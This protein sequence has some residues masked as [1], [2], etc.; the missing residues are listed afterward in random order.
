VRLLQIEDEPWDSGLA[1]Y[2]LTLSAELAR[3]GHEVNFWGRPHSPLLEQARAAGLRAQAVSRPWT[4]LPALRS[5]VGEL[6]IELINAHTG[7]AHSLAAA[8]AAFTPV[9]VVRTRG[10]A[11]AAA[12]HALARLLAGRTNAFIAA[13]SAIRDELTRNFPGVR[14]ELI[15]QGIAAGPALPMPREPSFG[16]LGR[17]DPVKGHEILMSAAAALRPR[18]PS[19]RFL[20]VGG[21][22]SARRASLER[23]AAIWT[24]GMLGASPDS[25]RTCPD[26]WP[27]AAS[28]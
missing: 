8:L 10:D 1:H 3:R 25:F 6:G 23:L 13:N 16:L 18:Y 24:S 28:G 15:A 2:A 21:G 4:R 19:A 27:F 17:L 26:N 5:R 20:A 9:P 22:A 12:R 7:S 11:R 14:V